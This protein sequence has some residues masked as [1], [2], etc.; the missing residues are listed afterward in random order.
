MNDI[1]SSA[2][3][4][5]YFHSKLRITPIILQQRQVKTSCVFAIIACFIEQ[6][7]RRRIIV[8]FTTY[9]GHGSARIVPK[10]K[11]RFFRFHLEIGLCF[12]KIALIPHCRP[13]L[14]HSLNVL[15]VRAKA[16]ANGMVNKQGIS[17]EK[18][19]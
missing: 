15:Q 18:R 17:K 8:D 14:S 16:L 4:F 12:V 2:H 5:H 9:R 19:S 3:W 7:I 1:F 10:F 13:K 11:K 6:Y